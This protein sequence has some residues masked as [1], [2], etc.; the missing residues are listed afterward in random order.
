MK[1]ARDGDYALVSGEFRITK[2]WVAEG[3]RYLVFHR[4]ELIGRADTA[5]EA[6]AEALGRMKR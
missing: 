1:W 5:D 2:N 4:K 3:W 6:K